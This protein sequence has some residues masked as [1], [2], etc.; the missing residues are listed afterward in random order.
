MSIKAYEPAIQ[1]CLVHDEKAISHLSDTEKSLFDILKVADPIDYT[2]EGKTQYQRMKLCAYKYSP[3]E[4]SLYIDVDTLWFPEK[5]ISDLIDRLQ[6]HNFFIGKNGEFDPGTKKHVSRVE[7][8]DQDG[9]KKVTLVQAPNNYTYWG[10]IWKIQRYHRLKNSIPQTIS[11]VFWFKKCSFCDALFTRT[12]EIYADKKAP[13]NKWANGKPDEYC[14]NVALSEMAYEQPN[15]HFVYF[16]KTNGNLTREV[17]FNNYWGM[18]AGGNR[19][20]EAVRSL[21]NDLVNLYHQAFKFESKR[22]HIDKINVISER[23]NY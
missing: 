15:T 6:A 9:N 11:G 23:R 1:I 13:C 3:F 19:L 8:I 17:M 14:F 21:Y 4:S 2:I 10:E 12:L 20:S 18:A 7:E 5:K 16:D 22:M